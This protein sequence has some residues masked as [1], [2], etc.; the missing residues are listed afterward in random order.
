MSLA[1]TTCRLSVS[2]LLSTNLANIVS[3]VIYLQFHP[4]FIILF[5]GNGIL[6]KSGLFYDNVIRKFH[7]KIYFTDQ[8]T[9]H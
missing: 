5:T 2:Y 6:S 4:V 9:Y 1:D 7:N 3:E 8:N